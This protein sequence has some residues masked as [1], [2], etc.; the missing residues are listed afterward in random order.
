MKGHVQK[1]MN[2]VNHNQELIFSELTQNQL[3][4]YANVKKKEI[5]EIKVLSDQDIQQQI[6]EEEQKIRH[7][8]NQQVLSILKMRDVKKLNDLEVQFA[9]ENSINPEILKKSDLK[10][11]AIAKMKVIE[12]IDNL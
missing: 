4:E 1:F 9:N 7:E 10:I 5:Q 6:V 8:T 3:N 11:D 12:K 2:S